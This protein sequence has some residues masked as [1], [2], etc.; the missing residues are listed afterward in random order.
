MGGGAGRGIVEADLWQDRAEVV[1][2]HARREAL[3]A[4]RAGAPDLEPAS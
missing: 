2:V 3:A 1:N 4:S